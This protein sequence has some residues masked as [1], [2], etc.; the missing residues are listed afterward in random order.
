MFENTR[1]SI[2]IVD[3][4]PENIDILSGIL[5]FDYDVL[6]APSAQVALKIAQSDMQPDIIL[7]D[8]MMP[9]MDGF[10][11]CEKLKAD[12]LTQKIP[13]IFVTANT[14]KESVSKGIEL[15]AYYYLTKP[16]NPSTVTAI[17]RSA[18]SQLSEYKSLQQEVQKA[19]ST[20]GLL[21]NGCFQFRTID[22]TRNL[23]LVLA[24]M[25]P[26]PVRLVSGLTELMV[27]AVEHGN[28]G[29][30]YDE[31]GQ[32]NEQRGWRQE[33]ERRLALPE[34]S[35]KKATIYIERNDSEIRFRIIDQGPGFEWRSYLEIDASRADHTHGR[36]IAMSRMLSFSS[37][38]FLGTGNEVLAIYSL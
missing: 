14:D 31:K 27:N 5:K 1:D 21:L 2:L 4:T 20:M 25:A 18:L 26:D 13:I 29:I 3:D 17:V 16:V 6:A 19:V 24:K 30:T 8:V 38:E 15:G 7:L 37:I 36:G 35:D 28:L 23:A 32:L 9:E 12:P 10:E 34:N 11:L 33:V 22:E